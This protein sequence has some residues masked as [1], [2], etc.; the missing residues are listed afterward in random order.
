MNEPSTELKKLS[1]IVGLVAKIMMI[2]SIAFIAYLLILL[3]NVIL[4]PVLVVNG[5]ILTADICIT[6]LA[7]WLLLFA[8]MYCLNRL[9]TNICKSG[10]PFT[11]E[12]ADY[13]SIIAV[14]IVVYALGL[15]LLAWVAALTFANSGHVYFDL[16][17]LF[18]AFLVYVI[19]LVFKYGTVLQ[20]ESDE[21]L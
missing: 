1:W 2:A 20:K 21:T 9:F 7:M 17:L 16:F 5:S 4:H 14:L 10:L 13:L 8:I 19:S 18:I 3:A 11:K 6:N 12:N 15:P